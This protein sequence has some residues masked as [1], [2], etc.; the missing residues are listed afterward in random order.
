MP[1]RKAMEDGKVDMHSTFTPLNTPLSFVSPTVVCC[2]VGSSVCLWDLEV[3]TKEFVYTAAYSIVKICGNPTKGLFAFCEGGTSPQAFVYGVEPRKLLFQLTDLTELELADFAFSRCGSRLF[4]LSRATSKRLLVFSTKTGKKLSGCELSLPS[5]FDKI[6]VFP[7]HKDSL[8]LI[9][10]SS[11]RL[12]TIQ[13]SY[14][15]YIVK[16][17]PA[18]L[19]V[20]TDLSVSAYAWS[21]SGQFL[22]ATRQGALL[23][24]DGSTGSVL[25]ACQAEQPITSIGVTEKYV[26]TAHIGNVLKFWS[27]NAQDLSSEE[28]S[29]MLQQMPPMEGGFEPRSI[30]FDLQQ[31]VDL[32]SLGQ[33]QQPEHKLMGQVAYLQITPNAS[34]AVLTTAE[35]EVWSFTLPDTEEGGA[36]PKEDPQLRLLIWFHTHPISDSIFV[37]GS[38]RLCAS[39]DEGGRLRIWELSR[40]TD[41]KGFRTLC[42]TSALTS[43]ACDDDGRLM[44]VGT[45]AGCL[46]V[47]GCWNWQKPGVM[48]S[49]RISAS[50]IAKVCACGHD[51]GGI[52]VAAALFNH[53][54]AFLSASY[55]DPRLVMYGFVDLQGSVD[56]LCW[57]KDVQF[58]GEPQIVVVGCSHDSWPCLWLVDAPPLEYEAQQ[59]E[60]VRDVCPV[61]SLKMSAT[62]KLDEKPTAV[63]A[64]SAEEIVVGFAGGALKSYPVPSTPGLPTAKHAPMQA[65]KS[66]TP[67]DQ[68]ITQLQV[69]GDGG[70]LISAS[71]DGSIRRTSTDGAKTVMQKVLHNP[72][73]GGVARVCANFDDDL[74]LST[75]GSDGL[76]VWS[77]PKANVQPA[78]GGSEEL[79]VE[80]A[81]ADAPPLV[82]NVDDKDMT[83]FPVWA[84]IS[85]EERE[86]REAEE[87]DDPE[88]NALALAQRRALTLEVE[89]LRKKLRV[90][91]DQ[92]SACPQLE[93]LERHEFCIDFEERDLIAATTKERCD[94]LRAQI[95]RENLVRQL[96][97][98]RLIKEFWDPMRTKGCLICSLSSN[99][100]VSNYPERIVSEEEKV[101]LRKLRIMRQVQQKEL[102]MLN[103]PECPQALKGDTILRAEP[104]ATGKESYIVNWWHGTVARAGEKAHTDQ[105]FL[106]EP[107][108]LVTSAR[109]RLQVHIL[110]SLAAEYRAAF[111]ELF[112]ACQHD[113]KGVMD[114]IKEKVHRMR[115]ILAELQIN[116]KV[117]E[118]ELFDAEDEQAVLELKDREIK[119]EKW[120]SPEEKR[121]IEEA[122]AKE[123]ERQRLLR[124]NDAGTR[125]LMQMMGGTLKTK[126]DLSALEITLDKEPWMDQIVEEEMTDVQ[127]AALK[128]YREKEKALADEQ[129]KYRK[130]LDAE[131]K[132]LRAEVQELTEQFE[133]VLK[134]LHHQRFAHDAGFFCQELYCVRLQ[135]ALLQSVED[136]HVLQTMTHD[137]AEAQAKL[138][139]AEAKLEQFTGEVASFKI[140]QDERVRHEREVASAQ[141]FRQQ[142]AQL[143]LA[144]EATG[145]LLQLFR[146][147][148][149]GAAAEQS[150]SQQEA[151]PVKRHNDSYPDLG[152][153]ADP[154]L[155]RPMEAEDISMECPEGVDE[156]SFQ[157]MLELRRE[158][159]QAELE[160]QLGASELQEMNGLLAHLE[161]ERDDAKQAHEQLKVELREHEDLMSKE[162]FDIEILFKLKQGQVE[163]PQAAVVT[164]YS[165]AVVVNNEVVESRNHRILELGKEKTNTLETIKE[166]RKKLSL[167]QWEYRMLQM[168]TSDLEERTKDVHMLRVTKGLQSLLKGGE[169]GRNKADA[170][171][172]ER[173]IEHLSTT[174]A[175]K[176]AAIKKQWSI[177]QTAAKQRKAENSMLEK[178]LRELQQ[179]VIQR[180][181]IR[182]LR[183]PQ[184]GGTQ[185]G[186]KDGEKPR[187][188]GGGGKIEENEATIRAAQTGFR[189]IKVRQTL[190]DTAKKHTEEI[191]ILRKELD[192]LR[193]KTFPSFVQ[194][195]EERGSPDHR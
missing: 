142:F 61:S 43:I 63:V 192:R 106:Y 97:R 77:D 105:Q 151:K 35:G 34:S 136:N 2:V 49:M 123:E 16:L 36:K 177:C 128:E 144:A 124:E 59:S 99:L 157:R 182:R 190:M 116:E 140:K 181:H 96:T 138:A 6:A 79:S 103:G 120:L 152:T 186:L 185:G 162:E 64:L 110:Q 14:E 8:A 163:V 166:F 50:G 46:H 82:V 193:Q 167:I 24:L 147:K 71:M 39:S 86:R 80:E 117:P 15:T 149:P 100:S 188:I 187:V 51:A 22:F 91:I 133:K 38:A 172:L 21:K 180:E 54:V 174:T 74:I 194:L 56:D 165:D 131:L 70:S 65:T 168:Q 93:Q 13:K 76:V 135:L 19:P 148:K 3:G 7:G 158:R 28:G 90:L 153:A 114:Q 130:Q 58:E 143:G 104:F 78:R 57:H 53:K 26:A 175:Q 89:G 171:L 33:N 69:T 179:N 107:F 81:S 72:Y 108:E 42:F 139:E 62:N 125:A 11:V 31:T 85:P 113:K 87:N 109:R 55:D 17:L 101:T 150:A 121:V 160:V 111:N 129:D 176:E 10:S 184:G 18:A 40:S 12:V 122:R 118:P 73:N 183:A 170:D 137:M 127:L 126:K 155:D 41:P 112:K 48:D 92:N 27:H 44:V 75:G 29:S 83:E 102:I 60:L 119:V 1:P 23:T 94:A 146:K 30:V 25:H 45:D 178:K 154:R 156:A 173:K 191:D 115:S 67:H 47:V 159:L 189:D 134:E 37:G 95:E 32:D 68:Y 164:D 5:R 88:L 161:K 9:R 66:F 98:D 4:A 84:P 169:E 195:H 141:H 132:K 145:A 52:Y 20:D